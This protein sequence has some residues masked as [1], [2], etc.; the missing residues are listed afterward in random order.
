M[1]KFYSLASD[2][3]AWAKDNNIEINSEYVDEETYRKIMKGMNKPMPEEEKQPSYYELNEGIGVSEDK[4]KEAKTNEE[5]KPAAEDEKTEEKKKPEEENKQETALA[6]VVSEIGAEQNKEKQEEN[7]SESEKPTLR[8][9]NTAIALYSIDKALDFFEKYAEEKG[10]TFAR[11]PI[12]DA[13]AG[14]FVDADNNEQGRVSVKENNA[15]SDIKGIDALVRYAKE[16]GYDNITLGECSPEY[17]EEMKKACEK[18]GIKLMGKNDED[19]ENTQTDEQHDEE[20]YNRAEPIAL[21]SGDTNS[22]QLEEIQGEEPKEQL[23]EP[24]TVE[25]A[26]QKPEEN[27]RVETKEDENGQKLENFYDSEDHLVQTKWYDGEKLLIDAKFKDEE[28][29]WQEDY[30]YEGDKLIKRTETKV[31][32]NGDKTI[33]EY[34]PEGKLTY[35][36]LY[37]G[38]KLVTEAAYE[39]EKL[40]WKNDYEY[41]GDKLVKRTET[42]IGENGDKTIDEY[43]DGFKHIW[44]ERRD[45]QDNLLSETV[46][47]GDKVTQQKDYT[48][49]EP[50][51]AADNKDKE[52]SEPEA[53]EGIPYKVAEFNLKQY[54]RKAQEN[55]HEFNKELKGLEDKYAANSKDEAVFER[56]LLHQYA[57][58]FVNNPDDKELPKMETA[59]KMY[60]IDSIT[61]DPKKSDGEVKFTT[62]DFGSRSESERAEIGMVNDEYKLDL[63]TKLADREIK[64]EEYAQKRGGRGQ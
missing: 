16:T 52:N 25:E 18:Y 60:G 38:D 32:E 24:I 53:K 48:K 13:A 56:I 26:Q 2:E 11:D 50:K 44:Q 39:D 5:E 55:P 45:A 33:D 1:Q 54:L 43:E 37:D 28:I 29:I 34:N 64:A 31:D 40:T 19:I 46:F 6:L 14:S 49:G 20:P 10:F 58:T 4:P 42:K 22:E 30:E 12:D 9:E 41:E 63:G 21:P 35:T 57:K 47:D 36:E 51:E 62:K 61:I 17:A 59:L 7:Q 8:T 15:A 27:L 3:K 23:A